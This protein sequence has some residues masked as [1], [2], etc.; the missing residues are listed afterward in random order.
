MVASYALLARIKAHRGAAADS[1]ELLTEGAKVAERL[2]LTRLRAAVVAERIRQ[3]LDA[4]R[5]HEARWTAQDLPDGGGCHGGIAV[6]VADPHRLAGRGTVRRGR[7]RR[8][9]ALLVS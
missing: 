2:G 3:L 5:V 9:G 6:A 7:S 8:A 1:A 4:R